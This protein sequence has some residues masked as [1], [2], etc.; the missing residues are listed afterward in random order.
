MLW[1]LL[2]VRADSGEKVTLWVVGDGGNLLVS[3]ATFFFW[4]ASTTKCSMHSHEVY[5][6]SFYECFFLLGLSHLSFV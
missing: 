2:V 5:K 4:G 3:G 6:H 1:A